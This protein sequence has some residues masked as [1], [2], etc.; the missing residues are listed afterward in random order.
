MLQARQASQ[1]RILQ[2]LQSAGI[3]QLGGVQVPH[4]NDSAVI[5]VARAQ[6]RHDRVEHR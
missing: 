6:A 1:D 3:G 5:G 2:F 4:S